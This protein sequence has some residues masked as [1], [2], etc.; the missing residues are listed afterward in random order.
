MHIWIL[1]VL[2]RSELLCDVVASLDSDVWR[3]ASTASTSPLPIASRMSSPPSKKMCP[4]VNCSC[5]WSVCHVEGTPYETICLI[6][7][8]VPCYWE[9]LGKLTDYCGS[10][11]A[12]CLA[13]CTRYIQ[14]HVNLSKVN[15]REL[16]M[17]R[18]KDNGFPFSRGRRKVADAATACIYMCRHILIASNTMFPIIILRNYI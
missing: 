6:C 11:S 2:A 12:S 15:R 3:F 5:F 17:C 16:G 10:F 9:D 13:F 4:D 8:T 18:I 14:R 7:V 1:Q